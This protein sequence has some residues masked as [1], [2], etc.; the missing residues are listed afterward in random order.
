MNI[1]MVCLSKQYLIDQKLGTL[2]E[3]TFFNTET[4]TLHIKKFQF[5]VILDDKKT[6]KSASSVKPHS[7]YFKIVVK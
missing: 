1:F 5:Q 3:M 6:R 2:N 7:C 4:K